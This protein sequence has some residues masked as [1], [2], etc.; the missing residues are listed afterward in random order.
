VLLARPQEDA[1][2]LVPRRARPE[3]PAP[4]KTRGRADARPLPSRFAWIYLALG[5]VPT[6]LYF[7]PHGA[8]G[9][10]AIYDGIGLSCV[11]VSVYGIRRNRPPNAI[12]WYLFALGQ[13][14][15]VSGDA[16]RA[17]YEIVVGGSAPF[18][19]FSD[20]AYVAA[21]P[22]LATSLVLLVRSRDGARDRANL[23]DVMVIVTSA[24]L[25][26]WVYLIEPQTHNPGHLGWLGMAIS[27]L[28]PLLDLLL[29]ALAAHLMLSPGA[30]HTS[31]YLLCGSLLALLVTDSAYTIGLLDNTYHTGSPI[32]FGYL[33]SYLLWGAAALHPSSRKVAQRSS[34]PTMR[35]TRRRLI[36]LTVVTLLAPCVR[37]LAT[38]RGTDLPPFT[39]VVPTVILFALVMARM[40]GL[41]QNLSGALQ[42]HEE[43][44]RRRRNSEARFGSLVEHSS[45]IVVVMDGAGVV[46]Y[47]SPSVTRVLGY[48]RDALLSRPFIE[49]VHDNDRD[50]AVSIVAETKNRASSDPALLTFRCRHHEGSTLHV[51]TTFTN[52]LADPTVGGIVLNA[53]DVTEQVALQSQLSHQAFH[54]PLTDL[55]NR[56]LFHDRVEHALQ[57]R[58]S[59]DHAVAVLFLDIDNFKRVN[60]SLGHSAGDELLVAFADR[61]RGCIR[62]ADTAARLG[63]DEFA[64]LLDEPKD[65]EPVAERL[66]ELLTTG[67]LVGCTEVFLTVSIGISVSD[68]LQ[69]DADELLRNAD[70]AMYTAKG[71]GKATAVVF[72][73]QM[74]YAALK[75]L[76]LESELRK[77]VEQHEFRVHYQPIVAMND[78]RAV[79]FEALV[80]WAHPERGLLG[81]GQFISAAEESGLIRAIGRLV[82]AE[83]TC[84]AQT[85]RGM[86]EDPKLSMCVNLSAP[87][88]A[89]ADL[90]DD[91][92]AA[93]D[94]SGLDPT[95]LVLEMTE[96]VLMSDTETTMG[97][98]KALKD[99]GVRLAVDDFGTGFSSFGYLR[100]FPIDIL[101][102]A[103]PFLDRIPD[104]EQEIALVR[105]M[106]ELAHSINLRV[107]AEGVEREEQWEALSEMGCDLV[108]GYL[109]ARPQGPERVSKLMENLRQEAVQAPTKPVLVQEPPSFVAPQPAAWPGVT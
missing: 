94:Q 11:A 66:K 90:V 92:R 17:Y 6:A 102:I 77:A 1:Q 33:A 48:G 72:R 86:S 99:L 42:R 12:A 62:I 46:L 45:D 41:V 20:I 16:I 5:V 25:L 38:L 84:Q 53:R 88:F 28:Y 43:A 101:K 82:V 19:G 44:E 78:R 67:F 31:Y 26:S 15:F 69:N 63:G 80:R 61:L 81:P 105:G 83:A 97:R 9:H 109:I 58:S 93:I 27:I 13:L 23:I 71:R 8:L 29:L 106:L 18:P 40:S 36:F 100:R 74:H 2:E 79:G 52:L 87:E 104:D 98:L 70:S 35:I 91:V 76:E 39:T 108:Q 4:E 64:V 73:P 24:G 89:S 22:I 32:D 95:R 59:S 60:D 96:S 7:F 49:L 57:R 50:A 107:V 3:L 68:G 30:R 34:G 21:Y 54:D 14:A 55:A 56:V 75:R 65:A 85:W 10:H 51:E 47:Q 37:I 103:K